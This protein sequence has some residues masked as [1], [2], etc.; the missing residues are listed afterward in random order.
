GDDDVADAG[1]A[2]PR[3][4]QHLDA[5]A[6]LG[7]GIV[8]DVEIRIHL[9]HGVPAFLPVV[10]RLLPRSRRRHRHRRPFFRHRRHHARPLLHHPHQQPVLRLAVRPALHDLHGV[11]VARLVLLVV[12][13]ADR[14]PADVLAVAR[15]LD[16]T[17]DL[18]ATGLVHLVTGHDADGRAPRPA[19]LAA[20]L[21][22][23]HFLS[24]PWL[25]W[26]LICFS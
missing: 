14:P 8:R 10:P 23:G 21:L 11:A 15:V 1:V 5:H 16:Q 17:R 26:A 25:F 9:N 19:L 24:A 6:L 3:P 22:L 7:A 18:D 4:A 12:Y 20:L 13:V 2:T